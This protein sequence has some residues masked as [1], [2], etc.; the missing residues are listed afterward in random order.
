MPRSTAPSSRARPK[1]TDS[2]IPPPRTQC[3]YVSI[4]CILA[5][6]TSLDA[7]KSTAA[8]APREPAKDGDEEIQAL[9]ELGFLAE[10]LLIPTLQNQVLDEFESISERHGPVILL[11]LNLTDNNTSRGSWLRRNGSS[12]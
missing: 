5:S 6:G 10:K 1:S 2:R 7:L 12:I 4:G 9:V 3:A 8:T 11:E